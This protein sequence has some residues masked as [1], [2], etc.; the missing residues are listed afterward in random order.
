MSAKL[1]I[2]VG[3]KANVLSSPI[4]DSN[5]CYHFVIGLNSNRKIIDKILYAPSFNCCY[6][7]INSL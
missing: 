6:R 1:F 4:P 2:I 5:D 3:D 7:Q